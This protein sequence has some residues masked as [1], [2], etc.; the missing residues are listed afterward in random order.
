[1]NYALLPRGSAVAVQL[2]SVQP[3]LDGAIVKP[4]T[5]PRSLDTLPQYALQD[6]ELL[7]LL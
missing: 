2:W 6:L 3:R 5:L 1:L 7:D 4:F